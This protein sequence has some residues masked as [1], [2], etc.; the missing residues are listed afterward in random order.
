MNFYQEILL[1]VVSGAMGLIS[2]ILALTIKIGPRLNR[3][4]QFMTDRLESGVDKSDLYDFENRFLERL[5]GRYLS[6]SVADVLIKRGDER[7][8][9][10]L[11][12]INKLEE[13]G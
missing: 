9:D 4:E 2:G 5:N 13:K 7:W 8:E 10:T 11:K 1:L 3:M 6:S 12:R